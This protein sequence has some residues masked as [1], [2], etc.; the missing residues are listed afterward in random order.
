MRSSWIRVTSR[1]SGRR[2]CERGEGKGQLRM[3]AET[4]VMWPQLGI[5]WGHQELEEAGRSF[6]EH[7]WREH[8]PAPILISNFWPLE[9]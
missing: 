9:Q 2:P 7:L 6:P 5:V 8:S 1:S 3:Q 4:G